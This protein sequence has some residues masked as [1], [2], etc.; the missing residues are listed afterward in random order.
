MK[1][2]DQKQKSFDRVFWNPTF[3]CFVMQWM[4]TILWIWRILELCLHRFVWWIDFR[5][6][7]NTLKF[8]KFTFFFAPSQFLSMPIIVNNGQAFGPYNYGHT[9]EAVFAI[10]LFIFGF[11]FWVPWLIGG[12]CIRS[13]NPTA[14]GEFRIIVN[15]FAMLLID[16]KIIS[17][18]ALSQS[19]EC[20]SWMCFDFFFPIWKWI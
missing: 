20:I 15:E 14:R 3:V 17:I 19:S 8:S 13:P 18:I 10:L 1:C 9:S 7:K 6:R 2:F 16:H 12:F 5:N 4:R 11:C